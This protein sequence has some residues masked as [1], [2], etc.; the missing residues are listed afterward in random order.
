MIRFTFGK[1]ANQIAGTYTPDRGIVLRDNPD[2]G[3][4]IQREIDHLLRSSLHRHS[5]AYAMAVRALT[6]WGAKVDTTD[7]P[8]P[9]PN[10]VY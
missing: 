7:M 8:K 10:R 2:M 1:G 5:G 4:S 9:D 3:A 6:Q